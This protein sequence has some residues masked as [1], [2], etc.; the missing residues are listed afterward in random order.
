MK[1]KDRLGN[2]LHEGD[3]VVLCNQAEA[4]K[5][6]FEVW[7]V[8]GENTS[9]PKQH[10]AYIVGLY[11]GRTDCFCAD[12]LKKIDITKIAKGVVIDVH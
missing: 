9:L 10:M 7:Q 2:Q 4:V 6:D 1:I 11:S 5:R 8:V 3:F 12:M